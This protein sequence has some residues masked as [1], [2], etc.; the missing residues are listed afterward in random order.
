M[1]KVI[2]ILLV[3]SLCLTVFTALADSPV[4][5]W[6]LNAIKNSYGFRFSDDAATIILRKGGDVI[7]L[8]NGE[9]IEGKWSQKGSRIIIYNKLF[10]LKHT[11]NYQ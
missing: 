5:I 8:E 4:G 11:N 9:E 3:V 6:Y 7:L 2:G 1:K 10:L